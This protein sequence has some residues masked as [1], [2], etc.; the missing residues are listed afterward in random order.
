[1]PLLTVIRP[2]FLFCLFLVVAAPAHAVDVLLAAEPE[3]AAEEQGFEPMLGENAKQ[4]WR[5]YAAEGWPKN[6][7]LE[8]GVLARVDG[9]GDIM[10][11]EQFADFELRLEWK[12]S[13]GGNSGILYRVSTGDDT[14]YYTGMECQILD[15]SK[16]G[17]GKNAMTSAGSL[18]GL[19]ARKEL[20]TAP[21]G[22]WNQV[23]IVVQGNHIEHWLNEKK[24]VECEI[25]SDD[26]NKR[27]AES[28][29]AEWPKFAK[30]RQ[31]HIALQEHGDP[32]WYRNVRIKRLSE[33]K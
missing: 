12:I 15:D 5:G 31:G 16:H 32:V 33:A 19:Y 30:N 11:V 26:W 4:L 10:T 17:N 13:P 28:K 3:S 1:M 24:V 27:L 18:Y 25:G 9:G 20:A 23:R 7:E 21:V 2:F 8:K 29:F 14:S 22:D 6:W